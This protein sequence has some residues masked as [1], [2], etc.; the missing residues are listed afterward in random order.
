MI[1]LMIQATYSLFV[2][3]EY[4]KEINSIDVVIRTSAAAIFG[5]FLSANFVRNTSHSKDI[6]DEDKELKK[7]EV[8]NALEHSNKGKE[9]TKEPAQIN[10][11]N[12]LQIIIATCMCIFCLLVL[13]ILRNVAEFMPNIKVSHNTVI[14]ISQFRDF[15]SS[16]V[17][18]LIGCPTSHETKK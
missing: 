6:D 18:F 16:C 3:S 14:T 15:V 13:I 17:G 1:I 4:S 10:L 8:I 11:E 7:L 5:Y 2:I 12:R 9:K